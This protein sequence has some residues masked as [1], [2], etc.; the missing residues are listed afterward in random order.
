MESIV[1]NGQQSGERILYEI[2]PHQMAKTFSLIRVTI[3]GIFFFL[4]ITLIGS[5]INSSFLWLIGLLLGLLVIGVGWWWISDVN[6][7]TITY[8]TDRRIIRFEFTSPFSLR[9]R[10]LFW[11][12]ALKAKAYSTGLVNRMLKVGV[13]QVE[14]HLAT[15]ENVVVTN[16]YFY[17]DIG[18]Y[19]DKILYIIKNNPAEI[20]SLKPFIPL[21]RGQRGE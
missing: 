1:F 15:D 10:A 6:G 3:V 5:V 16:V 9:K 7:K 17:E 13:V 11:N 21:P 19:I 20:S 18:N 4:I 14:P 2:H 8:I 12:E